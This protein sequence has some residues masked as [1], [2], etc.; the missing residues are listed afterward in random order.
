MQE[1]GLICVYTH[2]EERTQCVLETEI[3]L[4]KEGCGK[5]SAEEISKG[6]TP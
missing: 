5:K 2:G 3:Y 6:R 1:R 4:A